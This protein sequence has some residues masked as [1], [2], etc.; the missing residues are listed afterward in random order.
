MQSLC[1]LERMADYTSQKIRE[2]AFAEASKLQ[3]DD[4]IFK[5][6]EAKIYECFSRNGFHVQ[7]GGEVPG[8]CMSLV[9]EHNRLSEDNVMQAVLNVILEGSER[10]PEQFARWEQSPNN[11]DQIYKMMSCAVRTKS[12]TES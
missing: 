7:D 11:N 5:M 8:A 4:N 6:N 10:C 3:A 1:A 9:H 2:A 12:D